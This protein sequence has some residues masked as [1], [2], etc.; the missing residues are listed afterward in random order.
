MD[1]T[2]R[3]LTSPVISRATE[4]ES[5]T[6]EL[7]G[8]HEELGHWLARTA[9]RL[10]ARRGGRGCVSSRSLTASLWRTLILIWATSPGARRTYAEDARGGLLLATRAMDDGTVRALVAGLL[11][12]AKV[13]LSSSANAA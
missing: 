2:S 6:E 7:N 5:V 13:E 3:G 8:M 9:A 12:E 1:T 11:H 10:S 4:L